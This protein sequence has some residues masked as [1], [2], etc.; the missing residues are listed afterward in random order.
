MINLNIPFI[1]DSPFSLPPPSFMFRARLCLLLPNTCRLYYAFLSP[2]ECSAV[3]SYTTTLSY[4]SSSF[5]LVRAQ[6]TNLLF[7][8]SFPSQSSHS[9]IFSVC[10][11]VPVALCH[12]YYHCRS[13]LR[14][15]YLA[16]GE[17]LHSCLDELSSFLTI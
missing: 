2:A 10:T 8:F 14:S 9:V 5:V 11:N 1:L 17:V 3:P 13:Y 4:S 6:D 7:N 16:L 12:G 15:L